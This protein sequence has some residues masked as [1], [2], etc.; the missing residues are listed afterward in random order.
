MKTKNFIN[1]LMLMV[2]AL[3]ASILKR[4][5]WESI[6]IL[7]SQIKSLKKRFTITIS[8]IKFPKDWFFIQEKTK[9]Y[10][11]KGTFIE[12]KLMIGKRLEFTFLML[13]NLINLRVFRR[14]RKTFKKS[15]RYLMLSN[16]SIYSAAIQVTK[17]PKKTINDHE[18]KG[19]KI[20]L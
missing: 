2:L 5:K 18:N 7:Q 13:R 20:C 11:S 16:V 10:N 4:K 19:K 3:L 17:H 6:L 1:F 12:M 8:N 14:K 15:F 9:E